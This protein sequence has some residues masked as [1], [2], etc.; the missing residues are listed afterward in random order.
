MHFFHFYSC[1]SN[2]FRLKLFFGAFFKTNHFIG[3]EISIVALPEYFSAALSLLNLMEN[4]L[5]R[6]KPATRLM[7]A[8]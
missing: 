6:S 7:Q 8:Q 3:F 2:L 5:G 4:N 1:L